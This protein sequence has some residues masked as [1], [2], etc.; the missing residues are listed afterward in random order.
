MRK[1]RNLIQWQIFHLFLP[2]PHLLHSVPLGKKKKIMILVLLVHNRNL[3]LWVI[4]LH[5]LHSAPLGKTKKMTRVLL[6]HDH[7]LW[8]T[9]RHPLHSAPWGKKMTTNVLH[10]VNHPRIQ[11]QS[12]GQGQ[13]G[14]CQF[15]HPG[16]A[17]HALD[18]LPGTNL[19]LTLH[20]LLPWVE[21]GDGPCPLTLL[22]VKGSPS[23][24]HLHANRT[25]ALI[26]GKC[27]QVE[28]TAPTKVQGHHVTTTTQQL[29]TTRVKVKVTDVHLLTLHSINLKGIILTTRHLLLSIIII[30]TNFP[31]VRGWGHTQ[32]S[33][34]F[35]LLGGTMATVIRVKV[36]RCQ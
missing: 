9:I 12:P 24:V 14:Q 33:Q 27:I 36:N 3:R 34:D 7:N 29:I 35:H 15:H 32:G 26:S 5:P 13:G 20:H 4:I 28:V 31:L 1:R 23:P 19:T 2:C 25:K 17:R 21:V 6:R 10:Q 22:K 30:Q 18:A 11:G 16:K 8:A